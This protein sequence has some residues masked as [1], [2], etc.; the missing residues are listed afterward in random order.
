MK[1]KFLP[2]ALMIFGACAATSAM[3]AVS[4][5][6]AKQLGAEF[7]RFGAVKAANAD[8][9][10]PEYTG[11]MNP[12]A[13]YDPKTM[14]TYVDPFKDE[15]P[16]YRVDAKNMSQYEAMLTEGTKAM[17][18]QYPSFQLNV[19]PSHRSF[20]YPEWVLDNTVKN[21]TTAKLTGE[22]EGD[23]LS[24]ADK[25]GLPYAGVPFPIPKS[26]YEA[27]WNHTA[28]YN[29]AVSHNVG[30]GY[31]VDST[32][33]IT[34][35][36]TADEYFVHPWYDVKGT[37]RAKTFNALFGF[38]AKLTSPP[39]SAGVVFLNYYTANAAEGGQRVWFYTPG[40]RRVRQAPEFSYDVPIAAYGGVTVWDD[41][42]GYLGRMDRF[43]YKIVGR[44]EMLI[45]YNAFGPT[46]TLPVKELLGEKH[47]NP[48]AVRWEKHRVWV[49]DGKRKEGARHAYS[50]RTF[51]LDEDCWCIVASEAYDNGGALWRVSHYYGFPT[52][53]TG[54]FNT[55]TWSTNDLIKGNYFILNTGHAEPGNSIRSYDTAEGLPVHLTPQAVA[56]GGVR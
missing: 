39:S 9:S 55:E 10:V 43:D 52:Y 50:R 5:E 33:S 25:D 29:A 21:A 38:S 41:I 48:D 31:L 2:Y 36:P 12:V 32:G 54:G 20:R 6:E 34:T 37:L 27:I 23:A 19:Y 16:A 4:A 8:G 18:K 53:D 22:V 49:V 28:R 30:G 44:K 7:T 51:Y 14:A 40:Q 42:Y 15:K 11:G 56:A 17:L 46:N 24:G 26:G 35:L 45:P 13:G 3:S 47:I 1:I